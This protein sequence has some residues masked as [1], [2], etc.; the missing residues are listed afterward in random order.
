MTS[1]T[2][3]LCLFCK[4]IRGET[5]GYIVFED[6]VSLAFLDSRPLFPGHCLLVPRDHYPTLADLPATLITPLFTNAQLLSRAVEQA[7][8]AEGTFVAINNRVSQSVPHLHIH[9]VPRRKKDG[10]KGFFWPRQQ[11]QDEEEI[12]KV[13]NTLRSVIAQLRATKI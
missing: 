2:N 4:I 5:R 11:Y 8:A 7:L 10:L 12:L 13:Q 1:T 6:E 3:E 9:V